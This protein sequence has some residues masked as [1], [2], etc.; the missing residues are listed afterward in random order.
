MEESSAEHTFLMDIRRG[1][2]D[3]QTKQNKT[4]QNKTKQMRLT[5]LRAG[6]YTYDWLF[7]SL[8][9]RVRGLEQLVESSSLA[10]T[11][12]AVAELNEW[13]LAV[14]WKEL[15]DTTPQG[16]RAN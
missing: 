16:K 9:E 6:K 12:P 13:Q 4:K 1:K 15:R 11:P 3:K 10:D 7:T 14:R 8:L 2:S 5:F